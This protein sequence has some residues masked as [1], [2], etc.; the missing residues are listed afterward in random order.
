VSLYCQSARQGSGVVGLTAALYDATG[1]TVIGSIGPE[2]LTADLSAYGI[3]MDAG[4][5]KAFLRV[6]ASS[7]D[8]TNAGTSY[9][10]SVAYQ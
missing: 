10:C 7:Q 1:T 5:T 3:G 9:T 4:T 8:A 6:S 2:T